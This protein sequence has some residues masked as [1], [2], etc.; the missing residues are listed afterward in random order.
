M[1]TIE[2]YNKSHYSIWN[3]FVQQSKNGTFLF[4]RDFMEYHSDRFTDYSLLVFNKNKPVALLP[5]NIADN[6]VYS[7]QGLTYGGLLF[8]NNPG[9]EIADSIFNSITLYLKQE[10]IKQII[11]KGQLPI[12]SNKP[13]YELGYILFKN[14]AQLYRRDMNL[15]INY[16][17]PLCISKSKMKHYRKIC[18]LGLEIKQ[19]NNF[20]AFWENVLIPRLQEKHN[21][22]PV[23]T[24][25]EIIMLHNK[26][27]DN[28]KQ[29]NVYNN[30]LIIAG[31]TIFDSGKTVKSQYGAT[32]A[33][34]EKMRALD[35]LFITLIE[36]Y[37][38]EKSFFDMGIV[39]EN[40][41]LSYNKGLLKQKEELGCSIY[42]HD[43]Y[44]LPLS[45]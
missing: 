33:E 12:Y 34:G 4:H 11:I 43:F 7:H 39:N 42:L 31:L 13:T 5:A 15:A 24:L 6:T 23:H 18:G 1:Y 37:K 10:G 9:G 28:I 30:D 21:V 45:K 36:Q 17:L 29:Y 35:F 40:N 20:T 44:S 25:D 8:I 19:D 26:F 3:E 16:S 41:G 14:G 38:H 2:K 32:T 22:K 27:P